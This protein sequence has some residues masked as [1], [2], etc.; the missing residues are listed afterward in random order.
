MSQELRFPPYDAMM[1]NIANQI[2]KIITK[3]LPTLNQSHLDLPWMLLSG[4]AA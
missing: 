2:H 4:K 1:S 3:H